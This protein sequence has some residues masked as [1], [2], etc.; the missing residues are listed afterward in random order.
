MQNHA[1]KDAITA[2]YN[3]GNYSCA[4]HVIINDVDYPEDQFY[5]IKTSHSLLDSNSGASVGN[6]I[7][8]QIIIE[9]K[10]PSE[11]IPKMAKIQPFIVMTNTADTSESYEIPKGVFYI[12]TR[13]LDKQS[14]KLTL[15]GYDKILMLDQDYISSYTEATR[16]S[17]IVFDIIKKT[18]LGF[19]SSFVYSPDAA[20]NAQKVQF[21]AGTYTMREVLGFCAGMGLGNYI[22]SDDGTESLR[23]VPLW[24]SLTTR[25]DYGSHNIGGRASAYEVGESLTYDGIRATYDDNHSTYPVECTNPFEVS[26]PD[27]SAMV[28]KN[29]YNRIKDWTY[30]TCSLTS[31]KIN[32]LAELGDYITVTK[33]GV[34]EQFQIFNADANYQRLF[35][36]DMNNAEASEVEHEY[37][38]Y[39]SKEKKEWVRRLRSTA[40]EF[41]VKTNEITAKVTE[42]TTN[43]TTNSENISANS[44]NITK[45]T[46]DIETNKQSISDT[47][48]KLS[49]LSVTVDGVSAKVTQ[50]QEIIEG[51]I[52][53]N[54][55][56]YPY[57]S[58][59]KTLNG[60]TWSYN[61]DGS[62]NVSGTATG[63]VTISMNAVSAKDSTGVQGGI[64]TYYAHSGLP[65]T[66]IA[67]FCFGVRKDSETSW[68]FY[69]TSVQDGKLTLNID[70]PCNWQIYYYIKSGTTIDGTVV[71][72]PAL[73]KDVDTDTWKSPVQNIASQF[74]IQS[75]LIS[76]KVSLTD[77][78]GNTVVSK[79][80]QSATTVQISANKVNL[81]G[82]VTITSLAGSGT[83][84]IDGSNIK[85]GTIAAERLELTDYVTVTDLKTKGST[86]ING[87]NITT[88]T[89]N[90]D[91]ITTGTIS[92]DRINGG[93]FRIGGTS[94]GYG[95]L[96]LY[97]SE[98]KLGMSIDNFGRSYYDSGTLIANEYVHKHSGN[99]VYEMSAVGSGKIDGY[100]LNFGTGVMG[101][102]YHSNGVQ[103][104]WWEIFIDSKGAHIN[105]YDASGNVRA[106]L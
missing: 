58:D 62:I 95:T 65:A 30:K 105:L 3:T 49:E 35:N 27:M 102:Y 19:N 104:P 77:Y 82:Y 9:M 36:I 91:L 86:V 45:N 71:L 101:C 67:Q 63:A 22:L 2:L 38:A 15:T 14:G 34:S 16:A 1:N 59:A 106:Y 87:S 47:A 17:M 57:Y 66:G 11:T 75:G 6:V 13:E 92:A 64:G 26:F 29:A 97:D 81:S 4:Y 70:E 18:R 51:E 39:E 37:S 7:A 32:P 94:N 96:N 41:S 33:D 5:S 85:T 93:T 103:K 28:I 48:S 69:G 53:E 68:H 78:T 12:D 100:E 8:K 42:N 74:K 73:Y 44:T 31:A 98:N 24:G 43:I 55:I 72:R 79:I 25:V 88:G 40:A 83:T 76:S 50:T 52:A 46:E 99:V 80:N 84:T 10:K 54:I 89:I 20:A 90:A 56:P 23:F 21:T 60:I 61:L